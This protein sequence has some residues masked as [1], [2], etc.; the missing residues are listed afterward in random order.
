MKA[1]VACDRNWAIGYRGGLLCHIPGDLKYFKENTLGRCVIMGRKTLESLPGGRPLPGR[2]TVILSTT[3][4]E[5][6]GYTV[7]RNIEDVLEYTKDRDTFVCGGETVY[8]QF[9]EYCDLVLVTH[10]DEEFVADAWFPDLD[11]LGFRMI[12][13]SGV[14][15]EKGHRYSFRKYVR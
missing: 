13:E 12:W 7:F 10:I 4:E 8:R 11:E 14:T 15:E 5:G 9:I 3:L 1:I 6:E 2:E